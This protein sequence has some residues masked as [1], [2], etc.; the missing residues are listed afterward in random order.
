MPSSRERRLEKTEPATVLIMDDE[1]TLREVL[2]IVLTNAGYHVLT[3]ENVEAAISECRRHPVD[4]VLA[5]LRIQNERRKGLELLYWLKENAPQ[6]PAIM[7]T[8]YGS[9]D[10]AVEAMKAGATDYVVKP[11][12]NEEILLLIAR[13]LEQRELRRENEAYRRQQ[14][15]RGR[16]DNMVGRSPAFEE[17]IKIIHRVAGLSSTVLITGESGS[18]KEL[19]ARALHQLSP[20]ADKP[21]V[22]L[23][24]GGIPEMLLESE[25]FGYKKGAFTGANEDKEGFFVVANGG[26][27]FLDEIG[28]MP[29]PLQVKLLRVLAERQVMPVGGVV[30]V[31]VDV[32]LISA[33][34]R[35]LAE[36]VAQR[37]F[38]EDLYYRLNVIPIQVPPLRERKEDIPILA[39]H[40]LTKHCREMGRPPLDVS[41]EAEALLLAYPWPG[42]I[43]ELSNVMERIAALCSHQSVQPE[44]LPPN[45][46][47]YVAVP[48]EL[49]MTLPNEGID[50]EDVIA[51]METTLIRQA[52]ERARYSHKRA[53]ALLRLSPRSFRYRLKKYGLTQGEDDLSEDE[54][55]TEHGTVRD[56]AGKP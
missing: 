46:R 24:C 10:T 56:S 48:R 45:I 15:D 25:L 8:A 51:K 40:Y 43:R 17:L 41:P 36:L 5:D 39:R 44:D 27:L 26:T 12:R 34:H 38:R 33:T 19:V 32:R 18:G 11:F 23:N 53:A 49:P 6:I 35:D 42:N 13:A 47:D 16:L 37:K 2:G 28:E 55:H 22:A 20:R 29:L 52:L 54:E 7:M 3:A 4:V 9:V 30:P 14:V 31:T 50:L 1:E 21:F